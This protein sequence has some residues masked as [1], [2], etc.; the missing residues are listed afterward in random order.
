VPAFNKLILMYPASE[1]KKGIAHWLGPSA[2]II[3]DKL[4]ERAVERIHAGENYSDLPSNLK[5]KL[6]AFRVGNVVDEPVATSEP[7]H[8]LSVVLDEVNQ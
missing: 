1:G 3:H 6:A 7:R 2:E 8:F 4:L 5:A